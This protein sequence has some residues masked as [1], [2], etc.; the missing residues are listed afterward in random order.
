MQL[1]IN[2]EM[3]RFLRAQKEKE[4][5]DNKKE[6]FSKKVKCRKLTRRV[7]VSYRYVS[8]RAWT[9]SPDKCIELFC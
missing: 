4:G 3:L 7:G 6:W 9:S 1:E 8:S 5:K 2:I